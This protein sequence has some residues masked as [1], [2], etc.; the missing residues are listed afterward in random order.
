METEMPVRIAQ[1]IGKM[2][3]GG[4]ET[5][6]FNYYR[7]IDKSKI[8]FDFFYDADS[9]VEPPQDLI[10]MGARFY[11]L[12][13]YQ[14]MLQYLPA[15]R[16][17]FR[18]N[19]YIIVHSHINT[20]SVFPLYAAFRERVPVRIAHNHSVPGGRE[21]RRNLLKHFLRYL[22]KVFPTDYF[23]CSEKAGRWL[24]GD[25][26]YESGKIYI[27]NNAIDFSKF[28]SQNRQIDLQ[29][30][31]QL[32]GKF[33]VGHVGRFTYA[34]NHRFLLA[35][36]AEVV[37]KRPEAVLLLVGDGE[38]Q[39]E[40]IAEIQRLGLEEKVIL[41]GK[42]AEP[43]KYYPLMDVV[44]LPSIFEGLPVTVIEAQVSNVPILVSEAVV[45]EAYI[46]K[47][48][49][50]KMSLKD[51]PEAWAEAA[52]AMASDR[53]EREWLPEAE[54]YDIQKAALRLEQYYLKRISCFAESDK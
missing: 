21:W 31:Y 44:M 27:M 26:A 23:A 33:V 17:L 10:D 20:M 43:E 1:V 42:T 14:R 39:Q 16:K 46:T 54:L 32:N 45:Q 52:L 18:E 29:N 30:K 38:C 5:V 51:S 48:G 7:R 28:M 41:A 9:T 4:V 36:F 11:K 8:Q 53:S 13:P 19:S 40:I 22:A 6:V 12:P 34:K 3:A 49:C 37:K 15:L 24:F 35:I 2:W 47:N 50:R 25:K